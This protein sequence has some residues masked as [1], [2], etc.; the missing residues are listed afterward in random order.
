MW[1]YTAYHSKSIIT[2]FISLYYNPK[3]LLYMDTQVNWTYKLAACIS[4]LL[5]KE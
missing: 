5:A 4:R 2:H 1:I 3:Y